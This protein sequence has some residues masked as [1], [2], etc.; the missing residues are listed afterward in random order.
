MIFNRLSSGRA[1]PLEHEMKG[2]LI[3]AQT[4]DHATI[5]YVLAHRR[6]HRSHEQLGKGRLVTLPTERE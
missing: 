6:A 1:T 2:L 3:C 5:V 4:P